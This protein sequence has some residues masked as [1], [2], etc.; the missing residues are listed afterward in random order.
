MKLIKLTWLLSLLLIS[1]PLL[2]A[3]DGENDPIVE[4]TRAQ[5]LADVNKNAEGITKG[6]WEGDYSEAEL[7]KMSTDITENFYISGYVPFTAIA[8]KKAEVDACVNA[9]GIAKA[10][11]DS[12]SKKSAFES[13]CINAFTYNN[14]VPPCTNPDKVL[15]G[16]ECCGGLVKGVSYSLDKSSPG[17]KNGEVCAAHTDCASQICNFNTNNDGDNLASGTCSPALACFPTIPLNGECSVENP[18][19]QGG[20]CRQQ[21][22][23]L[24]GVSCGNVSATCSADT[25][26]CSGKCSSGKC[27]DKFVCQD[28]LQEG[29]KPSGGKQCCPGFIISIDGFCTMEMPP[30]ILPSSASV[31]TPSFWRTLAMNLLGSLAFAQ[32]IPTTPPTN[33]TETP[34][35]GPT[36]NTSQGMWVNDDALTVAQLDLIEAEVRKVLTIKDPAK[37]KAALLAIYAKRKEMTAGNAAAIKA[38]QKIGK[39]YTQEEYV[40]RYNIP[41]IKPKE[42]SSVEMCEFDTFKDNW[43]DSSN[44]HRNAELFVRAFEVSYSGKAT[45]DFWHLLD[46]SGNPHQQNLYTRTKEVMSELRD[47]RNMQREQM[48]YLDFVMACQCIYTFGPEKFGAEKQ[49]FFFTQCTGQQDN[50][51]CREGEMKDSLKIPESQEVAYKEGQ[52]FPNYVAMYLA[53]LEK[54]AGQGVRGRDDIDNLDSSAAG[55]NHEEVLVRWLRMRSCNQVD[56][57]LDAESVET[58]VQTL[59]E[60]INRAKKPVARLTNYWNQR[61]SQMEAGGVDKKI[62]QIWKDDP[63]KD[64]WYRGYIHTETKVGGWTKKIFKFLLFLFLALLVIGLGFAGVIA[65]G[66]AAGIAG[67]VLGVGMLVSGGGG[68][69]S[70][71]SVVESFSKDFPN[72]IIEDRLVK[73]KSCGFLGLFY[74]K[75]YSRI[76]HWPAFANRPGLEASFPWQKDEKRTCA[77]TLALTQSGGMPNNSCGGPFKGTMCARSFFRPMP[78]TAI[79]NEEAFAPWKSFMADKTLMD[80]V[81]PEFYEGEVDL[82]NK[83]VPALRDGFKAGCAWAES[84]GKKKPKPEDKAKFFPDFD[85]YIDGNANFKPAYQFGQDRIDAYKAAVK[86]YALCR[87][88]QECGA[89]EYD[90]KALSAWGLGDIFCPMD[91]TQ[92]CSPESVK[93]AELFSNYVYQMHFKWRHMSS[94]SGIGYPLAYLENYYL[95]LLHNIRLLTTLS[96]RRGLELDD[97]FNQYSKDLAIRRGKYEV[98][99]TKYGL[100]VGDTNQI[101]SREAPI[102]RSF[103]QLGFPLSAEFTGLP[104]STSLPGTARNANGASGAS[105]T[106]FEADVLNAARRTAARVAKDNLANKNFIKQTQGKPGAAERLNASKKFF[107]GLNSPLSSVRGMAKAGDNSSYSGIGGQLGRLGLGASSLGSAGEGKDKKAQQFGATGIS[108][109]AAG[110][111]GNGSSSASGSESGSFDVS[112]Y[113]AGSGGDGSNGADG[114]ALGDAARR[115]GMKE[116]DVQN[117]LDASAR[118]RRDGLQGQ[119]SDSLFDKVSKAY[120]RNLDRVLLRTKS[121]EKAKPADKDEV[122]D[123]EKEEIK[124]MLR[125]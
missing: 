60:D 103:R 23:G 62:T 56:V 49:A 95:S 72:V 3:E 9:H 29:V 110:G 40:K 10:D 26:C 97:A 37:R 75:N 35:T 2:A 41:A 53:K 86:K 38:G 17:K 109:P 16:S 119:E 14:P 89:K 90:G 66:L 77:Q 102:F 99:P 55:I 12:K 34:S 51:I 7:R 43:I 105:L 108:A 70:G 69:A 85:K 46:A 19:C 73:K 74:C 100:Q 107:A 36:P 28:C 39:T 30:F 78:D 31:E 5:T 91:A 54:M 47:N 101:I 6:Y 98:D 24:E 63:L 50:K 115:T 8:E 117:M 45:K 118:E 80:P 106:G 59:A 94:H 84:L 52:E 104:G 1:V 82:D 81:L 44:L 111:A 71:F 116:G 57:F 124:K 32:E 123:G 42:R 112:S 4:K 68:S 93:N 21:D 61:L 18:N 13:T 65:M 122:K 22:M 20:V 76:L 125:Q 58:K 96:V 67:G 92:P 64:T 48:K 15:A 114:S 83:W 33:E 88:L 87:D 11:K 79:A 25:E 120:M 27:V 121:A 113:G